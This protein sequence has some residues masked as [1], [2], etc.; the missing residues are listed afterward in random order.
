MKKITNLL[1]SIFIYLGLFS[2]GLGLGIGVVFYWEVK[3]DTPTVE[4]KQEIKVGS[5]K[6]IVPTST[7]TITPTPTPTPFAVPIKISIPRL[8]IDASIVQ[9]GYI[10]EKNQVGIPRSAMDVGW[11]DRSPIPGEPGV[12]IMSAHYD[13]PTGL[14]GI[15]YSLGQMQIG[16]EFF[17]VNMDKQQ[18]KYVVTQATNFPLDT[19]PKDLIYS[20]KE[21]SNIS[22]IT[23]SGVWDSAKQSYTHRLL[24]LAQRDPVYLTKLDDVSVTELPSQMIVQGFKEQEQERDSSMDGAYLRLE[25][26]DGKILVFMATDGKDISAV[27]VV[28]QYD[29]SLISFSRE[30]M[31][32]VGKF[33]SYLIA[34][35]QEGVLSL[36]LFNDLYLGDGEAINTGDQEIKI[37]EIPYYL[38]KD[39]S[40][41][42]VG[43]I[44]REG[45]DWYSSILSVDMEKEKYIGE[46]VLQSVLGLQVSE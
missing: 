39:T 42:E 3:L 44:P 28:M 11:Y 32:S 8:N 1:K 46:D 14:P 25:A 35:P 2:V 19:F 24:V 6:D 23:C 34:E 31:M 10:A 38:L 21:D 22:L 45:G 15:F 43:I 16:D 9:V 17:I 12:S 26:K 29:S 33:M 20:E 41:A 5:P 30:G 4:Q 36:S 18:L 7:P 37:A 27:D 40:S 13:T